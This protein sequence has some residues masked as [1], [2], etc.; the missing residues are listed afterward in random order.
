MGRTWSGRLK[1][2][3]AEMW[4]SSCQNTKF[5]KLIFG[6]LSAAVDTK[7]RAYLQA[8]LFDRLSS[9]LL[10]T[11]RKHAISETSTSSRSRRL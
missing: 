6:C 9:G 2:T 10:L 1:S 3:P 5:R 11:R 7:Q 4:C 8:R